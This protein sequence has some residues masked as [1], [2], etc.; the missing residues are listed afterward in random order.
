MQKTANTNSAI[1]ADTVDTVWGTSRTQATTLA[2]QV[3]IFVVVDHFSAE[4]VGHH[5]ALEE[6]AGDALEAVRNAVAKC[7]GGVEAGVAEGLVLRHDNHSNDIADEFQR[8]IAL[9]G[10]ESYRAPARKP[11]GS[12]LA[13]RFVRTLKEQLLDIETFADL[14]DLRLKLDRFADLYNEK[15]LV[16]KHDYMTPNQIREEQKALNERDA[17]S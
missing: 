11:K 3:C 9:L 1:E 13:K 15:W 12:G 14:E 8:E 7:M 6:T 10:I 5:A 16:Q 17:S 2:G 4:L